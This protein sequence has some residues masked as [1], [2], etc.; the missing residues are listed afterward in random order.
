MSHDKKVDTRS[1]DHISEDQVMRDL[2]S[3][4]RTSTDKTNETILMLQNQTEKMTNLFFEQYTNLEDEGRK[5]IEEWLDATKKSQIEIR[6]LYTQGMDR[7]AQIINPMVEWEFEFDHDAD[8]PDE[9]PP[10]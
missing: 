10:T 7:I 1:K 2:F 5:Y 9:A 4:V 8:I 3:M 6:K